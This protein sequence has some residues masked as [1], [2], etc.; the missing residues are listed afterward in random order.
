MYVL[1]AM[2]VTCPT[3]QAERSPLKAVAANT[4]PHNNKEKPK[5]KYGLE[6]KKRREHC[7]KIEL[8]LPPERRKGR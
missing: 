6:K 7:S 4:A 5:D 8:V 3:S 2:F 1:Y